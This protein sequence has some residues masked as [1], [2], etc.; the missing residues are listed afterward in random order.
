MLSRS[1]APLLLLGLLPACGD[2]SKNSPDAAPQ[3][4]APRSIDAPATTSVK[5]NFA[6]RFGS[7]PFSC[8]GTYTVGTPAAPL[9]VTDL[10]FYVSA[11]NLL[12][13]DG[14]A[15]AVSLTPGEFQSTTVALL[16][17]ENGCGT[18]GGTV[19]MNTSIK[20][21]VT[22]GPFTQLQFTLGVPAVE[23]FLDITTASAPLDVTAMYWVWLYGYKFFKMDAAVAGTGTSA[24]APFFLHLGSSGCPGSNATAGPTS[25]CEYPNR[26]TYQLAGFNASTSTVVADVAS[27]LATTDVTVNT[28]GTAPG[29]M[30]EPADPECSIILPMMGV[31]DAAP[32]VLFTV[33]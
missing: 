22:G 14:V 3:V 16:D 9:T 2:S 4:D 7:T 20:G 1:Y 25:P 28:A 30:S 13:A 18:D 15:S 21:T 8:G 17:F 27:I 12:T 33:E 10:R 32:Q 5:L 23:D 6:A 31:N 29:C 11:V 24:G 19:D 26:V